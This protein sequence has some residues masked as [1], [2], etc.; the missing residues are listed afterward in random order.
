MIRLKSKP[1]TLTSVRMLPPTSSVGSIFRN[2]LCLSIGFCIGIYFT[3]VWLNIKSSENH[4]VFTVIEDARD[5]ED[6]VQYLFNNTRVLCWIMTKPENH[7]TKAIHIKDTWGRRCNKLLFMSS[8]EDA[9]LQTIALPVEEGRQNLWHKTNLALKYIYDN[10]LNDADWFLKADDDTYVIMENLRYMLY[11]YPSEAPLYF[12]CKLMQFIQQGYMSGGAGYVLSKSS[13]EKFA[14]TAYN[15]NQVCNHTFKEED[16]QLGKCLENIGVIA[17][18]TR[19]DEG[20]ERFIPLTPNTVIPNNL[21]KWYP[22]LVYHAM[23]EKVNCCSD[24]AI[25]FHYIEPDEFYVMEYLLYSLRPFGMFENATLRLPP[26]ITISQIYDQTEDYV[27]P[28][29]SPPTV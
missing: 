9:V 12:G 14:T 17:G 10:H 21:S 24:H 27:L 28:L 26:K 22:K 5:P 16:I 15:N 4:A 23:N 29:S 11:P 6:L 7:L 19:D 8:Q 13:L 2:L 25:S 1:L 20:K 18:D 3:A